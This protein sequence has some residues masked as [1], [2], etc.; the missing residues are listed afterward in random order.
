MKPFPF[1]II[2]TALRPALRSLARPFFFFFA[3]AGLSGGC[4]SL[5]SDY[6]EALQAEFRAQPLAP[7][8][9]LT[10]EDIAPLPEPVRRYVRYSGALGKPVPQN[11]RI[12]FDAQMVRKRGGEP[13]EAHSEQVNFFNEPVRLFTMEASQYLV[14]FRALHLY[15]AAGATFQVRVAGSFNVVDI[16]GDTLTA[17]ETVTMLN[18][19]CFFAPGRLADPRLSWREVDSSS[20]EATYT[21]GKFRVRAMLHVNA[22]GELVNFVSDDRYA[23]ENDGTMRNVR[24]STP[25]SDYREFDGRRIGTKG[26]AIYHYPDGDFT[27]GTFRLVSVQYDVNG[28]T[29]R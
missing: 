10:E 14:P 5:W 27:Y 4:H 18:D 24:W 12:V 2:N 9:V 19:L 17:A 29:A 16:A 11:V 25:V 13:M 21:N 23:L 22:A 20:C 1:I 7:S 8:N 3:A 15:R 26:E 28:G 6:D